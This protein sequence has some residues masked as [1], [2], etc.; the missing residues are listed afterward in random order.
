[1]SEVKVKTLGEFLQEWDVRMKDAYKQIPL[2]NLEMTKNWSDAQKTFFAKAFY[3][4]RGHFH[5]FL[6]F[7]GNHAPDATAK[8]IVIDNISEEFGIAKS[9]EQ[10]YWEFAT[11]LGVDL[12]D[13]FLK[14]KTYLP[15]VREFNKGHIEWLTN[16]DWERCLSA[17][18]AYERL[19]N[20]DYTELMKLA[21]NM[22][23]S[24][25]ALAFFQ[26]HVYVEHFEAANKDVQRVWDKDQ[27]KV[28]EAFD[29][30]AEHQIKM[31]KG[32]SDIVFNYKG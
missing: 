15:F 31:W 5:D 29:F 7:M 10:L 9:H 32:L 2:F 27:Q 24:G 17:F 4:A 3:H 8:R 16:H 1:M 11:S 20:L 13:E 18:A 12:K 28:I 6:W 26:V 30:I 21:E 22:G 25:R 14:E 23:I 19:D